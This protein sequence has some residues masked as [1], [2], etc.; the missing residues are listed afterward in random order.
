MADDEWSALDEELEKALSGKKGKKGKRD[1]VLSSA[2]ATD[3][4]GSSATGSEPAKLNG[5]KSLDDPSAVARRRVCPAGRHRARIPRSRRTRLWTS[6]ARWMNEFLVEKLVRAGKSRRSNA[7]A[8]KRRRRRRASAAHRVSSTEPLVAAPGA[9][10][11]TGI[12]FKR[13][14]ERIGLARP[15]VWRSRRAAAFPFRPLSRPPPPEG[16]SPP[17]PASSPQRA[18]RRRWR[19]DPR[20]RNHSRRRHAGEGCRVSA[21]IVGTCD[22]MCP[23]RERVFRERE[24][25]SRRATFSSASR[26]P[27]RLPNR[28]TN[29]TEGREPYKN[30]HARARHLRVAVREA[31]RA[32]R[33]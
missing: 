6:G 19:A 14:R 18:P 33:G 17:V 24:R 8:R 5:T 2:R 12:L 13:E 11:A 4:S 7:A 10:H 3:L 27:R 9:A 15:I 32:H 25:A 26:R 20:R 30:P 1:S 28:M 22:E 21:H 31:I 29:R 16:P 23:E